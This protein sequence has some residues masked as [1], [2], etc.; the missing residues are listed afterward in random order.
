MEPEKT[1]L[2]HLGERVR[3]VNF[4]GGQNGSIG[5]IGAIGAIRAAL[6]DIASTTD[7]GMV[8]HGSNSGEMTVNIP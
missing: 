4:R 5:A 2:V 1:V 6:C 3:L 7:V 8:L